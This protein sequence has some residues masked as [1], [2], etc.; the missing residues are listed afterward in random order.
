MV[1]LI[2]AV[3]FAPP[4]ADAQPAGKVP[5][6]GILRPGS[7]PDPLVVAILCLS[8]ALHRGA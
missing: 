7:A 5:R 2:V 4:V 8:R 6:I 1:M 3:L